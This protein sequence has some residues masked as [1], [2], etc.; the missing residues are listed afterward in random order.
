MEL[1]LVATMGLKHIEN[2]RHCGRKTPS[3]EAS[4]VRIFT[5]SGE[6]QVV[7]SKVMSE[8][9]FMVILPHIRDMGGVGQKS[10]S[11]LLMAEVK[12]TPYHL[13]WGWI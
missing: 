7:R 5:S 3:E 9:V 1:G 6:G 8:E 4:D 2:S 10:V 11:G 13:G 12:K